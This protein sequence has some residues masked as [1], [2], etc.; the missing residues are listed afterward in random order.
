MKRNVFLTFLLFVFV[1]MN[2]QAQGFEVTG[3]VTSAEDGAALPGV[4]VV[5]QGTTIGAVTNFDGEYAI[6]VPPSAEA[7]MFSFVGM[8]TSVVPLDG[9]TT[10]DVAM[11][12]DAL[13]LDEVVVTAIGITR[14]AKALGYAVETVSDD[15]IARSSRTSVIDAIGGKVAGVRLN[16][17]SGEAG[18]S[19]FIEIRGSASLTRSNQPL[20]V[21]DGVPIDNSGNTGNTVDGVTESNRAIDINPDDVADISILKGG[22]ATALYGIRAAN[23]AV[24]ITTKSGQKSSDGVR[25]NYSG[26]VRI[27]QVSQLPALQSK[28]AQGSYAY[29]DYYN[30]AY[31][32]DLIA[33]YVSPDG[34]IPNF[35]WGPELAE[36]RYTTDPDYVPADDYGWE[37]I[38]PMNEWMEFWDP[39]GRLVPADHPLAGSVPGMA[40][41][42]YD[43]FQTG[44]SFKNHVD[45]SGG[46]ARSTFYMSLSNSQDEGIVPNNTFDKTSFKLSGTRDVSSKLSV[47]ASMNY[48][49]SEGKRI[50]KGSNISGIMLGLLR[51]PPSFDNSGGYQLPDG[52]QRTYQGGRGYDNPY[53]TANKVMYNDNVDRLLGNFHINY[54]PTDW[55]RF[56]YRLG[57]D[58]W[59]KDVKDYF[60]IGSRAFPT[61]QVT[62]WNEYNKD[63]NSDLIM[64]IQKQLTSDLGFTLT[65]GNNLYQTEYSFTQATAFGLTEL[66]FYNM[67]NSSDVRGYE[68]SS[69]KR[70]AAFYGDVALDFK[71]M[72]FLNATGRQEWSTTMP[73]G[74]NSFFYPSVSAGFIFTEL[75]GLQGN[76]MLPFGKLRASYAQIANDAALYATDNYFFRAGPAD[77]WT[78]GITYPFR[79]VNAFTLGGTIGN[80]SLR[81]ETMNSMEVGLDLRFLDGRLGIDLGYFNNE[82]N[83]LLLPQEIA[84]STGFGARYV[85]AGSMR[86]YG[87]ELRLTATPIKTSDFSWDILATWS[88][89]YSEVTKLAE[90]VPNLFLSGFVEPQVRAVE[91]EAYRTLFGLKWARDENG[92]I[93]I[94]D[95][96]SDAI[97][98]GFPQSDPEM[99]AMGSVMPDWTAGITNQFTYKGVTLSALIDIKKGGLMW[100]GTK[101][102]LYYFGTHKDTETRGETKVWEGVYGH[103]NA[104]GDVVHL[105][106]SGNEVAGPG[107]A[108]TTE[109]V[110]DEEWYFWNGEGSGFTGPSEPYV[111]EA[112]WVR[113]KELSLAYAIPSK[114]LG[115]GFVRNLEVYFTG[116]NLWLSTPYTGV[117]PETSLVGN[118]NG[119]GIDYFNNP[120]TKSFTFGLR[121]G[122]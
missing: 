64:I 39:N 44:V 60:E 81:P 86:T 46:D 34:A 85:N 72:L 4:S 53:W 2:L 108:N 45:I 76:T 103:I 20:F 5:V 27:E 75:P 29:A 90:N 107:T 80:T 100:N 52:S 25:V 84:P 15:Q 9:R 63:F 18:A 47:G 91:G 118:N 62:D 79:G 33:P 116:I 82:N 106:G 10:I 111:E 3:K 70:T 105:D 69:M 31:G 74:D 78:N 50:Q 83:D 57:A 17:A 68:G 92:N 119:L 11:E 112:D 1:G 40:Y 35:S 59:N 21:V 13:Q 48:V 114:V 42:H 32:A 49:N 102:A 93:L 51:T 37:G 77:G 113:L 122:F 55:M 67:N 54:L 28:Y 88:N 36:M 14:D 16:R 38:T 30:S 71:G 19:T 120:G 56:T 12:S 121:A 96:P 23:G 101:G 89:P 117:D 26:S 8:R 41:D 99:Q 58:I 98:D 65:A 66:G 104:D 87:F 6:T 7:L 73:E 24:I 115:N 61:G 110:L 94:N 95:N 43:F 109:V 97:M 22:A